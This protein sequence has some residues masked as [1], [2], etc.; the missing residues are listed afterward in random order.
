MA[1]RRCCAGNLMRWFVASIFLLRRTSLSTRS[2]RQLLRRVSTANPSY[3]IFPQMPFARHDQR[4]P[5]SDATM[6][7]Y[8][9]TADAIS[10]AVAWFLWNPYW[11]RHNTWRFS[12]CRASCKMTIFSRTLLVTDDWLFSLCIDNR[13]KP[14]ISAAIFGNSH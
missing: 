14:F 9:S 3:R 10:A 6:L 11:Q 1:P 2:P 8:R 5:L 13:C 7:C 12:R 4:R